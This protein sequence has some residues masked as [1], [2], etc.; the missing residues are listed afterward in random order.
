MCLVGDLYGLVRRYRYMPF[1][2]FNFPHADQ[3]R[4]I[5]GALHV[6]RRA[7]DFYTPYTLTLRSESMHFVGYVEQYYM[8]CDVGA[9][10]LISAWAARDKK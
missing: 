5:Y 4:A 7:M 2:E 10:Q 3:R 1:A 9:T 8:T 6:N